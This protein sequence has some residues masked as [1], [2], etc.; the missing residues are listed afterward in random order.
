MNLKEF[1]EK[2]DKV[3]IAFSGGV[4]SSYLLDQAKLYAK[5]VK[6]Y[7]V[8]SAFQ[9]TFELE[10]AK[11]IRDFL[12]VNMEILDVDVFSEDKIL[13]NPS[14]RCYFCKRKIFSTI[15]RKAL[16]DGYS[17][18]LDGTNASDE[19]SDRPGMKAKDELEVLS[20]LRMCNLTKDD[21][22]KLSKE[23]DLFTWN[24]PSYSCLATRVKTGDHITR[25]VLDITERSENYLKSLGFKDFRVRNLYGFAKIEIAKD[26]INN[27]L[28]N[29]K[30]IIK[31]LSRYYNGVLFDLEFRDE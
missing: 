4:D 27:L 19:V 3:A 13:E 18:L 28:E 29:R 10:D 8:K 26:E 16:D 6:A 21:I 23:R 25:K 9:P 22:R 31:E 14:D 15:K 5:D 20:P 12:S 17:I 1:F 11:K 7:Y 24:K 30:Q 2:Y